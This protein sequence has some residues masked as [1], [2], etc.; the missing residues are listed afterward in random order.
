MIIS[1]KHR[2]IFIKTQKTAGT[3]IEVFLSTQCGEGDVVTPI[4]PHLPP[5]QA[6][7]H[8]G[9]YNHMPAREVIA[10]VGL[11]LWRSYTTFTVERNP[12]DKVLSHYSMLKNSPHHGQR[13]DLTIEQYLREGHHCLNWPAYMDPS[14][15]Q[16]IV[17]R[18]LRYE[19]LDQDLGQ[20]MAELGVPFPGRLDVRAKSEYRTDR[21]PYREVFTPQ[22]AAYVGRL[23]A[24]EIA[25]LGYRF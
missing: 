15:R 13:T 4:F 25:L 23:Y 14:G 19:Q 2:F 18:I 7:N 6:R 20:L 24:K 17:K 1:H 12:W 11:E 10:A 22:E 8:Q 5:H 9:F 21:R 3:S 16:V